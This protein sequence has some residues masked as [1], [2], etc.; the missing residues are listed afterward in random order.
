M[1]YILD[2]NDDLIINSSGDFAEDDEGLQIQKDLF[3]T[4]KNDWKENP[5][6]G[7]GIEFYIDNE[8]P[9]SLYKEIREQYTKCGMKIK[10]IE[11]ENGKIKIIRDE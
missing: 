9:D 2:D 11:N 4:S 10:S 8:D 7:I 1:D 6:I 3:I 5:T